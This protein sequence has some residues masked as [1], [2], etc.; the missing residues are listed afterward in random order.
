MEILLILLFGWLFKGTMKARK[1]SD[2]HFR[3]DR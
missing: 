1:H 2:D 3:P